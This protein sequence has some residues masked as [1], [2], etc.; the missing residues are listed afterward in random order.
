MTLTRVQWLVGE[1]LLC[2]TQRENKYTL[3]IKLNKIIPILNKSMIWEID[4][5]VV[6]GCRI[7]DFPYK[8][9]YMSIVS[10]SFN[11]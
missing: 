5:G 3:F 10:A 1:I 11:S 7:H 2:V 8:T 6:A 4:V 9:E